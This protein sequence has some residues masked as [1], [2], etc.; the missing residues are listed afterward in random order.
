MV[1][2]VRY[3]HHCPD[4]AASAGCSVIKVYA[5]HVISMR[6]GFHLGDADVAATIVRALLVHRATQ[7]KDMDFISTGLSPDWFCGNLYARH[8]GSGHRGQLLLDFAVPAA[9]PYRFDRWAGLVSIALHPGLSIARGHL[10]SDRRA[11]A[12]YCFVPRHR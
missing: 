10:S 11:G 3:P 2:T 6:T 7:P 9:V 8:W 1:F 4:I 12:R 5:C